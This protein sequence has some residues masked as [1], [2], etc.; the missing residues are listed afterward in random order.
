MSDNVIWHIDFKGLAESRLPP[1]EVGSVVAWPISAR[2]TAPSEIVIIDE[3]TPV[4]A[5]WFAPFIAPD[6]DSA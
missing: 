3:F 5:D 6:G 4:S 1:E 2:D